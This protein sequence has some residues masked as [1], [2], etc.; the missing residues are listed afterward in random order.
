[1]ENK[2]INHFFKITSLTTD[3]IQALTESME[4]KKIQKGHYLAK[5]GQFKMD[6]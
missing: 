1:M 3:E 5:E 4:I 6:S 2:L